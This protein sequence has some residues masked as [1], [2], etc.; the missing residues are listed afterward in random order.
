[1]AAWRVAWKRAFVLTASPALRKHYRSLE[2]E[3]LN[4]PQ[5]SPDVLEP[6]GYCVAQEPPPHP[7]LWIRFRSI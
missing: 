6:A 2:D 5:V 1:M 3:F 7:T 4:A